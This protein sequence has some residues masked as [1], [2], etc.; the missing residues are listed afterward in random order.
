M[1]AV[2]CGTSS[3]A[4]A[5][6]GVAVFAS[7]PAGV[8]ALA[9]RVTASLPVVRCPTATGLAPAPRAV[10]LPASRRVPVRAALAARLSVYADTQG[11]MELVGPRGW[12]CAAFYGAD[13]S[14]G[15]VIYPRGGTPPRSWTAG[16]AGWRLARTS[17]AA[18]VTGLETSACYTC[19]LAQACP[20]FS[21]AATTL[22]S[23]LGRQVCPAR[24]A[25][26]RVTTI[27]VG[28]KGFLDPPGT[29]GD[30]VPSGGLNPADGVLT[31]H[32]HAAAGSWLETCMLPG[33]D[34]AECAAILS[35]FVAWYG[36]R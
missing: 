35:A 11:V 30:G 7:A 21:A 22:R 13:G 27:G 12:R 23:Y 4:S 29:S 18:A 20:L 14:G 28:I 10:S 19:A 32:P 33:G 6:A 31:Y 17:A 1:L 25:A 36:Q 9:S 24:P 34:K 2:G 16:R 15:V 3:F 8:A 26:E 5:P